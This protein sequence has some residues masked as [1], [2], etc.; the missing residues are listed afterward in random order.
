MNKRHAKVYIYLKS[1][2]TLIEVV[3]HAQRTVIDN[4]F[5]QDTQSFSIKTL[6]KKV[7]YINMDSV[8]VIS[9]FNIEN[10]K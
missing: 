10:V 6:Q 1:G 3:S 8:E 2:K 4:S 9:I 7:L 5:A